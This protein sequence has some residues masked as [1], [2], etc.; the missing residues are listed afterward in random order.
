MRKLI[1]LLLFIAFCGGTAE[2]TIDQVETTTTSTTTTVPKTTSV[3]IWNCSVFDNSSAI[4][5]GTSN[6]YRFTV[7]I[8][9]NVMSGSVD[10]KKFVAQFQ[11]YSVSGTY[12]DKSFYGDFDGRTLTIVGPPQ[13]IVV[14]CIL[15]FN[16]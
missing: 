10:N 5:N 16:R 2:E 12:D 1:V 3:E 11:Q 4:K 13:A 15:G 6:G 9:G 7:Q 8:V 14:G